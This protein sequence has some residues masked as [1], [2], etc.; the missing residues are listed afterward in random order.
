M[1]TGQARGRHPYGIL[2]RGV[3]AALRRRSRLV[4]L[5][6][7]WRWLALVWLVVWGTGENRGPFAQSKD[8]GADEQ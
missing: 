3:R 1:G 6:E 4:G 7:A 5:W 2:D 8:T